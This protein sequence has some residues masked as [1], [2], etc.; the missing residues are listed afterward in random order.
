MKK[1]FFTSVSTIAILLMSKTTFAQTCSTPPSCATL[2]YTKSSS[3][4]SGQPMLKCPLDTTKVFCAS[5]S[6]TSTTPTT[7]TTTYSVGDI[8]PGGGTVAVVN[9]SGTGGTRVVAAGDGTLDELKSYCATLSGSGVI[10][11]IASPST[12]EAMNEAGNIFFSGCGYVYTT[13]SYCHLCGGGIGGCSYSGS[14]DSAAGF[15]EAPF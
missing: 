9:A 4:C 11:Q 15:C 5:S 10:W 14:L 8:A 6:T 2:G 3:D 13:S 1:L 7:P 12:L